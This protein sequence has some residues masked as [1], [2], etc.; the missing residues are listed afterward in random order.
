MPFFSKLEGKKKRPL[1]RPEKLLRRNR[2]WVSRYN[3]P[4]FFLEKAT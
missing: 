3:Y 1:P 4:A 2:R